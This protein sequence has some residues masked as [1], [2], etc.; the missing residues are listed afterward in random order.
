MKKNRHY[1]YILQEEEER[2][3]GNVICNTKRYHIRKL[4]LKERF[5]GK[6]ASNV[7]PQKRHLNKIFII[8]E[9][10]RERGSRKWFF[11]H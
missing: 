4:F 3:G 2:G 8:L 1:A 5:P 9:F 11:L 10:L 7:F 6:N